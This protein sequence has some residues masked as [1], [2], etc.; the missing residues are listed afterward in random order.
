MIRRTNDE[1]ARSH[2]QRSARRPRLPHGRPG[3][4]AA[5]GRRPLVGP[6]RDPVRGDRAA[7]GGGAAGARR[8]GLRAARARRARRD[9]CARLSLGCRDRD[10]RLRRRL[11]PGHNRLA[12]AAQR[13]HHH[14]RQRH[15]RHR[16][17]PGPRCPRNLPWRSSERPTAA[18]R[19]T[20]RAKSALCWCAIKTSSRQFRGSLLWPMK[21]R[22]C[23]WVPPRLPA[24]PHLS[25]PTNRVKRV[26]LDQDWSRPVSQHLQ[27]AGALS[28]LPF[29]VRRWGT[30][31]VKPR[32]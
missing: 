9:R 31:R 23:R 15:C 8:V 19:C 25:P 4:A 22:R 29:P 28:M 14:W 20:R 27:D 3:G 24:P 1:R 13:Q 21:T 30:N 32:C 2:S 18:K 16:G 7:A 5:R 10:P 6:A 11:S 26:A 12:S 17:Q